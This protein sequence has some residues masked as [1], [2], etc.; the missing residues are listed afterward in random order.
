LS[1]LRRLILI[2][3]APV[4]DAGRW[5]GQSDPPCV[6]PP[7]EALGPWW[8]AL[9]HV[10]EVVASPARRARQTAAALF[11]DLAATRDARLWEQDFGD[12][13][14]QPHAGH[15]MPEGLDATGL[16]GFAPPGGESFANVCDRVG[17]ALPEIGRPDAVTAV[18]AH[19]GVVRAALAHALDAAPAAGIAFDVAPLSLTG[20]T[21]FAGGGWRVDYVN[22]LPGPP[23]PAS[24]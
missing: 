9:Q 13:D 17:A 12:W 14:G 16:A 2:R 3:H 1:G 15:A 22:R 6:L 7:P 11:P 20:L 23:A 19:A 21:A 5:T 10:E 4:A 18:V 8:D 24:P